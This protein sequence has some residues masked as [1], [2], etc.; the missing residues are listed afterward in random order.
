MKRVI[1]T[2]PG[3]EK[4][5]SKP[6]VTQDE[7]IIKEEE[8]K[9]TQAPPTPAPAPNPYAAPNMAN[10][11]QNIAQMNAMTDEQLQAQI[12]MMKS[13]KHMAR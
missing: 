3:E 5:S 10:V 8:E 6:K 12:D 2:D 13:N 1:V 7:P 9:K 11:N 4:A